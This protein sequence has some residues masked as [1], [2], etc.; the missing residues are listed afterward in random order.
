MN[1]YDDSINVSKIH[2]RKK[3]DFE[4]Y[5]QNLDRIHEEE[6]KTHNIESKENNDKLNRTK[7]KIIDDYIFEAEKVKSFTHKN[8]HSKKNC[9]I[10]KEKQ[11]KKES[12]VKITKIDND[13]EDDILKEILELSKIQK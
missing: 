1:K 10:N 2:T 11:N 4:T 9:L 3:I 13:L 5:Q 7:N 8:K 12:P 6:N